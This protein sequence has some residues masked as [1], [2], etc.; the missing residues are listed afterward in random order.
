MLKGVVE[1]VRSETALAV[2]SA[3]FH[4]TLAEGLLALAKS[5]RDSS[6]LAVAA[7]SGGVF[8]NRLLTN[9]LVT[10]L[11]QEGFEVLVNRTVPANDGGLALGQGAIAANMVSR[12]SARRSQGTIL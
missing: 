5:A 2:V 4:N 7:L 12:T 3:K 1:D 11:Q 10:C 9:R 8:C 6:R